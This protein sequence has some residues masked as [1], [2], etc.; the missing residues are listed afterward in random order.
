MGKEKQGHKIKIEFFHDVLCTWCYAISPRV[1]K[2]A[3]EYPLEVIH[4]SFA[5][6]PTP[7]SIIEI[8]GSK[9]KGKKEILNHWRSANLNDDE[10]RI[11]AELMEK[12]E[13]DYPYSLPGLL[14]CKAAEAVGGQEAH[15]D[16]FDRVQKAHLTECKNIVEFDV[17]LECA[18]DIR[19][20]IDSWYKAFIDRKTLDMIISDL[21]RA[22]QYG[23]TG[24][25]TLVANSKYVLVGAQKYETI[26]NWVEQ[27][28]KEE[29]I[30]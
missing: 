16:M 21:E 10:H 20:D 6:A 26:K 25:P 12:R 27:I 17:L 5:L 23:I 14:A 11:N 4:K 1:R 18:R 7:E 30:K 13:F 8:F 9:E 3:K 28:I 22:Y 19:I 2:I 29:Q 15:W 24:V